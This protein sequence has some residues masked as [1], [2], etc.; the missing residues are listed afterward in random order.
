MFERF[1][2]RARTVVVL[3][4]EQA[5]S[6]SHHYIGTEHL[7]LGCSPRAT[8]SRKVLEAVGITL[9]LARADVVRIVG[10]T[11]EAPAGRVPFTP[12]SKTVLEASLRESLDSDTS[13]SARST[14]C[15]GSSMNAMASRARFLLS[16]SF[17][18]EDTLAAVIG[19]IGSTEPRSVSG[20]RGGSRVRQGLA[21]DRTPRRRWRDLHRGSRLSGPAPV[22]SGH[23]LRALVADADSQAARALTSLGASAERIEGAL[24]ATSTEGTTDETAEDAIGRIASIQTVEGGVEIKI[25]DADLAKLLKGGTPE[26]TGALAAR[27][28]PAAHEPRAR[29]AQDAGG[30][31]RE[32]GGV[33]EG[34]EGDL[35]IE[36]GPVSNDEYVPPPQPPVLQEAERRARDLIDRQARRRGMTRR[37]FLRTSMAA[38]A[39]LFVLDA[40]TSEEHTARTGRKPGGTLRIP[41]EATV[42][43]DAAT[44]TLGGDEF[45]F[46]V[47]THFLQYDLRRRAATSAPGSRRRPAATPTRARASPSSTTSMRCSCAPTRI[48]RW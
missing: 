9:D 45:V 18:P 2:D 40:C 43:P 23:I 31:W 7:L 30:R 5:R 46:D 33:K 42:D 36:L 29:G 15:S 8:A 13:T 4:Q 19:E 16:H 10:T 32:H 22:S 6:L 35:P 25:A 41:E 14:S 12:K 47:Q 24:A 39:V 20:W 28:R 37:D 21:R 17:S 27:A 11:A 34:D 48:S 3:A 26:L 1:T 38:A 44:E